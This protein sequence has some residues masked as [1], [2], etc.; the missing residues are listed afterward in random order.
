MRSG[1]VSRGLSSGVSRWVIGGVSE[2]ASE[3]EGFFSSFRGV[4]HMKLQ[5]PVDSCL[6]DML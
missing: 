5:E 6:P 3:K 4:S 1:A 2:Y